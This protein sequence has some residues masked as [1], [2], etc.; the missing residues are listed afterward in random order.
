MQPP[1]RCSPDL[2]SFVLCHHHHCH[3]FQQRGSALWPAFSS[4]NLSSSFIFTLGFTWWSL[5]PGLHLRDGVQQTQKF[6]FPLLTNPGPSKL[7]HC[8]AWSRPEYSFARLEEIDHPISLLHTI[9]YLYIIFEV[10]TCI[11]FCWSWSEARCAHPCQWVMALYKWPL[12]FYYCY[13]YCYL[14]GSIN[15]RF[16]PILFLYI[17]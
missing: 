9:L 2:S 1:V 11:Y 6:D 7:S 14:L 16:F 5:S 13:Y 3:R 15:F 10:L 17:N 4:V 12:L 8:K